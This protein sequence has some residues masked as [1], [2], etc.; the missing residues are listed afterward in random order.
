MPMHLLPLIAALAFCTIVFCER[1]AGQNTAGSVKPTPNP[2]APPPL[3][4]ENAKVLD[5]TGERWLADRAVLIVAG[6]IQRI[7][8]LDEIRN[9]IPAGVQRIDASGLYLL[10]GLMDLHT[11]LL[12]HAYNETKWDDQVLKE[13]LESRTIR[14]VTEAKATL[15]AG[16]TTIRDL[17]TEGAGFADVALRDAINARMIPGP[18]MVVV[19]RAIVATNCY[20]PMGFDPR[21]AAMIPKGGQE[22]T[23]VDEMRKAVREQIAAGA[24]WIKVYADY[25]RAPGAPA[26]PTFSEDELR[27]AVE[28]ARSAGKKVSAHA[29]TDEGIRRAVMAGVATIEHGYGASRETLQL[30][31]DRGVTLCPT[32]A[33]AE[34]IAL[35]AGWRPQAV[36]DARAATPAG[37][38]QSRASFALAREVGVTIANGSDVGVFPHGENAWELELLVKGGMKPQEALAAATSIAAKV[39]GRENDLGRI[40]EGFIADLVLLRGDALAGISAL[41][42]VAIVVKDGA[43]ATD[44]R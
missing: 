32:M 3:L 26:T 25:R 35:Y 31:K 41:R 4:I 33:A 2:K 20:G 19:T 28:E 5:P 23:G 22:V 36:D 29:T 40:E 34:A 44:K 13:S 30:M 1:A 6:R 39:I 27:A 21:V 16:F 18:R 43:I 7:A 37:V 42:Q 10:P 9:N 15:E 8:A 14:G 12:L 17:G 24:D 38:A 11:H